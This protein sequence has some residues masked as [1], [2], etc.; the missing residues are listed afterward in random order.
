VVVVVVGALAAA[1]A[2][3]VGAAATPPVA[4]HA[5]KE[6]EEEIDMGGTETNKRNP[7]RKIFWI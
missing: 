3:T 2:V 4:V 1:E 5:I 6:I 7:K